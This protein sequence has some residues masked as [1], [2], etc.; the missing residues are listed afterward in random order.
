M[1]KTLLILTVLLVSLTI[2]SVQAG[3]QPWAHAH[4]VVDECKDA[5]QADL[6]E[7]DKGNGTNDPDFINK[8]NK[9]A[10]ALVAAMKAEIFANQ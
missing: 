1:N 3:V 9:D 4:M 7:L 8:L 2:T 5:L 10:K 6:Q